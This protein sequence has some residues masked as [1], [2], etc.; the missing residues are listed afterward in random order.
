MISAIL[1]NILGMILG[2]ILTKYMFNISWG[3]AIHTSLLLIGGALN[4]W[5]SLYRDGRGW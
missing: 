3:T 1:A 4:V 2:V 5:I